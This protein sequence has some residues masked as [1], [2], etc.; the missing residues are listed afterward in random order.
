[1]H[2]C[3]RH[4]EFL[5]TDAVRLKSIRESPLLPLKAYAPSFGFTRDEFIAVRAA[6]FA[7][8][9]FCNGMHLGSAQERDRSMD[10]ETTAKFH[11][12]FLEWN[13]QF[14]RLILFIRASPV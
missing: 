5:T 6:L 4:P 9:S 7:L 12:E 11:S 3:A 10:P 2:R 14:S 13:T 8:A 1:M